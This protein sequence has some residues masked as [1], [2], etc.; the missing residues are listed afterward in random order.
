MPQLGSGF[1][2][3][4]YGPYNAECAIYTT[5]YI[6]S[7]VTAPPTAKLGNAEPASATWT[8]LGLLQDDEVNITTAQA[9]FVEDRRGFKKVLYNRALNQAGSA[10]FEGM[11]VETDPAA[12][13]NVVG[14]STTLIGGNGE[15]FRVTYDQLYTFTVLIYAKNAY[16][17]SERY[18]HI[19]HAQMTYEIDNQKGQNWFIKASFEALQYTGL[20]NAVD[21][22]YE[23]GRFN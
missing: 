20:N 16:D 5:P 7:G 9:K 1:L 12:I 15:Y 21:Y 18:I 3:G 10:T 8:K 22:I 23:V 17:N 2:T 11:V 13:A 19:P 6:A 14:S 4:S